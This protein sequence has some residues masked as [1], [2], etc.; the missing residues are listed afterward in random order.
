MP[1]DPACEVMKKSEVTSAKRVGLDLPGCTSHPRQR[2]RLK[3]PYRCEQ[4][5]KARTKR[6]STRLPTQ[7]YVPPGRVASAAANTLRMRQAFSDA[8][9]ESGL[10]LNNLDLYDEVE[11]GPE[12]SESEPGYT[13]SEEEEGTLPDPAAIPDVAPQNPNHSGDIPYCL[14]CGR[15][16]Q[17]NTPLG[18]RVQLND[19]GICQRCLRRS[20]QVLMD[21]FTTGPNAAPA[22]RA[23]PSPT[24]HTRAGARDYDD[25]YH[26]RRGRSH[27][28]D[29][30]GHLPYDRPPAA[31]AQISPP[32]QER[33][34]DT[35]RLH[36]RRDGDRTAPP[37]PRQGITHSHKTS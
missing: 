35:R 15:R 2:H 23:Y 34:A 27:G 24:S 17:S 11:S 16:S 14:G 25:D 7:D 29:P 6:L 8:E 13:E 4:F 1:G 37:C 19:E 9:L 12:G 30:A 3:P 32:W 5:K 28:Y 18:E 33:L 31:P 36:L 20:T 10:D 22:D 26:N 21:R